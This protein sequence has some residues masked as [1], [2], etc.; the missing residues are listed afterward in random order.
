VFVTHMDG[1]KKSVLVSSAT[2]QACHTSGQCSMCCH[3][4]LSLPLG[5]ECS[6][7]D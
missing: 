3:V 2:H 6:G 1:E 5:L 4:I 7:T